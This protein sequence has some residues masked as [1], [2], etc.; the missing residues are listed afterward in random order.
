MKVTHSLVLVALAILQMDSEGDRRIWGYSLSKRS[1]VRSGVL[2]P[3]L[4][5][6]TTE[7]WLESDW[8][9]QDENR[10]RPPRRY[11]KL[12]DNGRTELGAVAS[13]AERV[14]RF[15]D[16]RLTGAKWSPA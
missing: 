11:Y 15:A 9:V 1:G 13:Q 7:G 5:R 6:M 12:T 16:I 14:Q 3:Q 2:Y 10:K 8:E 4:D